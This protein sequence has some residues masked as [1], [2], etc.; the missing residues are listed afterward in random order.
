MNFFWI[1]QIV[2]NVVTFLRLRKS[3]D[4]IWATIPPG[5]AAYYSV[6]A[7][8]L[9]KIPLV[10]DVRDPLISGPALESGPR[11][12]FY[13]ASHLLEKYIYNNADHICAVTPELKSMIQNEY[14]ILPKKVSVVYNA[15]NFKKRNDQTINKK[16]VKVFFA[17]IFANYQII[18]QLIEN[19]IK[20]K[21]EAKNFRFEL[22]GYS[23]QDGLSLEKYVASMGISS[24]I[25]ILPPRPRE[26]ILSKMLEADIVLVPISGLQR[27]EY[28][29]YAV[30]LKFYEAVSNS[31]PILLFGGTKASVNILNEFKIGTS[32]SSKENVFMKLGTI[33]ENF[34]EYKKNIND[35]TFSRAGEGTKLY[36]I[37]KTLIYD[38][39]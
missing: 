35:L 20:H 10:V 38:K 32:C 25:S 33:V 7:K 17:G 15:T 24:I 6:I 11:S 2:T 18:P 34:E 37:I 12:F 13:R 8:K 26:E 4:C 36:S 29:D 22:F 27:Q 5:S 1:P 28:F 39:K 16:N 19:V 14:N 30:P 31:K 23:N 21:N 9:L 3:F